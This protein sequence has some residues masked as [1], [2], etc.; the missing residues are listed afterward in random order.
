MDDLISEIAAFCARHGMSKTRFGL[1]ALNDKAFVGQIEGGRDCLRRTEEKVRQ[2]MSSY[3]PSE[4][5]GPGNSAGKH[6]RSSGN[7]SE[8]TAEARA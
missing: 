6:Q 2:F 3:V 8:T 4:N 7:G 5:G 1:L